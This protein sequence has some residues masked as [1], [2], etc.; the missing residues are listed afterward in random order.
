MTNEDVDLAVPLFSYQSLVAVL[1]AL[2]T[3]S[4]AACNTA[5]KL[6]LWLERLCYLHAAVTDYLF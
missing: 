2:G 4:N 5:A 3:A 1:L 6:R